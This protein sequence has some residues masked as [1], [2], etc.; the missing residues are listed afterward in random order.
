MTEPRTQKPDA[1]CAEYTR[2][3]R[4]GLL[5]GTAALAGL[6]TTIGSAVVTASPAQ[7]AAAGSILVVLSMRGASDGLSL[8][9][10]HAD[11]VYYAAR[12]RIAIP[13]DRLLA[14]DGMFGLHPQLAPLLP[15]WDAGRVGVVHAAGLPAPNRSHFAAMEEIEDANPGSTVRQG[16]L[17]RLLGERPG[18]SSLQ[19]FS[20]GP[21]LSTAM[22]GPEPVMSASDVDDVEF[23]GQDRFDTN[24]GRRRSLHTMWDDDTSPLGHSMAATFDA[25]KDFTPV[26]EQASREANY[27]R[28]DLGGA[29]SEAARIVRGNVGVEVITVDQGDWDMHSGLGTPEWGAMKVNAADFAGS[30]AAFFD[31]LGD[32][33]SKVTLVAFSE[34]GRRVVENSNHGL[35]HG[36]GNAMFLAGAGVR[37][38]YHGTWPGL[39]NDSDSD[40]VVTTDYRSVLAEVVSRRFNAS[41]AA[42][43]PGFTPAPL[44]VMAA[45]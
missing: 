22:Y 24:D 35:D 9:V 25:V 2:M 31:D 14:K 15:M 16:W 21:S 17:N 32:Q 44:G 10:P 42:V 5:G 19:G 41:T 43:F 7:A 30:I 39:T 12:P 38:G 45:S 37:G 40:L 8:V 29:L 3:S 13:S 23:P 26:R 28:T 34:F 1:C 11:P 18:N 4:R 33:A 27:P 36:H 20:L 6:S